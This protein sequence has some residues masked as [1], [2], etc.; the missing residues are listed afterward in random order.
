LAYDRD[1]IYVYKKPNGWLRKPIPQF[2]FDSSAG[3]YVSG[4][5]CDNQPIYAQRVRPINTAFRVF[6]RFPDKFYY[7]VPYQSSDYGEE[8]WISYDGDYFY[9]YSYGEWRRI[10][11]SLF[12]ETF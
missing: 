6:Q 12:T 7:R 11:M 4:Y 1:Y 5:D 2:D 10:P 8:G 3:Q 9:I